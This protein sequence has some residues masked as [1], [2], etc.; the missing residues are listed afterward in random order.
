MGAFTTSHAVCGDLVYTVTAT[1]DGVARSSSDVSSYVTF[2]DVTNKLSL[3][4]KNDDNTTY[5]D[6][7]VLI[8]TIEAS[9]VN[10][11]HDHKASTSF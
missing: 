1:A 3:R 8:L 9:F 11:Q 4:S 10:A 7:E 5:G 6:I 2:N